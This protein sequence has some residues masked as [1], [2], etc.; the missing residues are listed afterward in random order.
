MACRQLESLDAYVYLFVLTNV[1][2]PTCI[3]RADN[4]RYTFRKEFPIGS[5]EKPCSACG[6]AG[7]LLIE[8]VAVFCVQPVLTRTAQLSSTASRGFLY[9][10]TIE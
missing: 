9:W 5:A 1:V 6:S 2:P 8:H 4:Q 7:K 3:L 10:I